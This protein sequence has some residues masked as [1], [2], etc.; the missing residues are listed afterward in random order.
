MIYVLNAGRLIESG[1]HSSLLQKRGKY[2]EFV[3]LQRLDKMGKEGKE[4]L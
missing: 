3:S 1:T 4:L 2:F